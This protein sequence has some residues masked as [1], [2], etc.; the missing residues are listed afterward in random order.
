MKKLYFLLVFFG[1]L[2]C[3]ACEKDNY[4]LLVEDQTQ[5][6]NSA[7]KGAMKQ[8]VPFNAGFVNYELPDEDPPPP[9][10]DAH[11]RLYVHGTGNAT[12]LGL[13]YQWQDQKWKFGPGGPEGWGTMILTAAN[14]DE[15]WSEFTNSF[16]PAT[17][18]FL[19]ITGEGH[20]T[21]GTGRFENAT[22]TYT[23]FETYH[24]INAEGEGTYTGEI[25]Y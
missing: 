16:D 15:L 24:V 23:M 1:A 19:A 5:L 9:D 17:F 20:F 2:L 11:L 10:P 6:E 14:G 25:L 18:P 3:C 21:G 13:T 8:A 4:D 12:H 7:L 22:G